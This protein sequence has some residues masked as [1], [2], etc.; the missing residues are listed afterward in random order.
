MGRWWRRTIAFA[1]IALVTALAVAVVVVRVVAHRPDALPGDV[2]VVTRIVDGDT[3]DVH[4]A[5][6]TERIRFIGINTP[7]IHVDDG[8]PECFGPEAAAYTASLLPIGA[9]VHLTRDVVGRDDYGRLLAY[10]YRRSD[11]LF[12]NSALATGGYA[13]PMTIRPNDAYAQEFASETAAADRAGLG[14][15][16]ACPG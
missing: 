12:V 14:L 15:W 10:I 11:E 4:I 13:R 6:R 8:P 9:E 5:G 2:G 7:E 3:I 1:A 16:G